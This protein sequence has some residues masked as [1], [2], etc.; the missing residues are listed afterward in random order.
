[1]VANAER[2]KR[3][4][5]GA[6]HVIVVEGLVDNDLGGGEHQ[7][8]VYYRDDPNQGQ[9][10]PEDLADYHPT[11]EVSATDPPYFRDQLSQYNAQNAINVV[12]S[13]SPLPYAT[14]SQS[15]PQTGHVALN[16]GTTTA[17]GCMPAMQN[18]FQTSF[19]SGDLAVLPNNLATF[20]F[21][22][23][24][25]FTGSI[26]PAT[27][28]AVFNYTLITSSGDLDTGTTGTSTLYQLNLNNARSVLVTGLELPQLNG[29]LSI[30]AIPSCSIPIVGYNIVSGVPLIQTD[31]A[32]GG[33]P[34]SLATGE[35]LEDP[36]PDLSLGGPLPL[37]FQRHYGSLLA[38]NGIIGALGLNW[39][40]NFDTHAFVSGTDASVTTP[41]GNLIR[42]LI[43][44]GAWNLVP[45]YK[46]GYEFATISTGYQFLDAAD[47]L[48]YTFG[49]DG[50]LISIADRKINKLT[51]TQGA[52][53]PT[54]IS[55][56]LG[57]TL[58]FTYSTDGH[59]TK[60]ADQ[61][62]RSVS[63]GYNGQYLL[64][65]TDAAGRISTFTISGEG[66]LSGLIFKTTLPAQHRLRPDLRQQRPRRDPSRRPG[67]QYLDRLQHYRSRG[68]RHHRRQRKH[69]HPNAPQSHRF[70]WVLRC[71][72]QHHG[73]R[74]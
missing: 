68:R 53:G 73:H 46:F 35:L 28:A 71:E 18:L 5:D 4:P 51:V 2:P 50:K 59:I 17:S 52:F 30:P 10:K 55:D 1:M 24:A 29:T 15:I 63:F 43:K 27:G 33:D 20:N 64:S 65:V 7:H 57:R 62:G 48:L 66:L 14:S 16:L 58:T 72:R 11:I 23:L 25:H 70:H 8:I 54:Q 37:I 19:L 42:F 44:G 56:G 38:Y 61:S 21:G 67:K 22:P 3:H 60:V 13:T 47:N 41:Q 69:D 74:L 40:H 39:T 49:P 26:V 45:G 12:L 34:V 31:A 36:P 6:G 9:S 32:T